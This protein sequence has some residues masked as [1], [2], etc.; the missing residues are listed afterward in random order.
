[1]LR[2][3]KLVIRYANKKVTFLTVLPGLLLFVVIG[4]AL[5][6]GGGGG[7]SNAQPP[8]LLINDFD[9]GEIIVFTA[10]G[11]TEEEIELLSAEI[12]AEII[13][14]D[15]E[16]GKF[17]ISLPS[18]ITVRDA[19]T[20][21]EESNLVDFAMPNFNGELNQI[22]PSDSFPTFET[23]LSLKNSA[24][25]T[26]TTFTSGEQITFSITILNLTDADQTLVLPTT[27]TQDF[28]VSSI[29]FETIFPDS[30]G[31]TSPAITT[32]NFTPNETKTFI[33]VWDQTDT[34]G[35][36]V[37]PGEYLVQGYI[38]TNENQLVVPQIMPPSETR[39]K[40]APFEIQ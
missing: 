30:G 15:L 32:L 37:S 31:V 10:S 34:N 29:D 4:L 20:F 38:A 14:F 28:T 26:T 8:T 27:Q 17:F 5:A 39:S 16:I 35:N 19:E 24:D 9:E 18:T 7:D 40:F 33:E 2:H 22:S 13:A 11:V 36:L 21:F 3:N 25:E 12:D 1:M 23:A 6:C